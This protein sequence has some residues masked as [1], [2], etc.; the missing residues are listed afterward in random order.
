MKPDRTYP[1]QQL[2]LIDRLLANKKRLANKDSLAKAKK[3]KSVDTAKPIVVHVPVSPC[4]IKAESDS[5]R[6]YMRP[7][8]YEAVNALHL[9]LKKEAQEKEINFPTFSDERYRFIINL[10]AMPPGTTVIIYE[11]DN[12]HKKRKALFTMGDGAHRI[13]TF[14]ADS[15]GGKFYID[16]E[17]PPGGPGE[18]CAV[19][20]LGYESKK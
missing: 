4:N 20:M 16:Y 8:Q 15:K 12:T 18:C 10:S 19:I 3:P 5:C 11:Q 7:F 6:H 1:K 14:D 9:P 2:A 17:I 13:G